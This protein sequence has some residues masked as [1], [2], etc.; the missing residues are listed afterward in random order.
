MSDKNRQEASRVPLG[1]KSDAQDHVALPVEIE[2]YVEADGSVTF[3]DLA[4]GTLPLAQALNPDQ[5]LACD[6]PDQ[7][8]ADPQ[9]R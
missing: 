3:A 4:E 1:D 6:L 9:A 5:P 2:I 7:E 8:G